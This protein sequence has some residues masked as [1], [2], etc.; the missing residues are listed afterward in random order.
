MIRQNENLGAV[1]RFAQTCSYE[2]Q[3]SEQV[4]LLAGRLFDLLKPVHG[5]SVEQKWLLTAAALLHDIGWMQ[6][7]SKHHKMAMNMILSDKT[8]PLE[9]QDRNLIALIARY[10]RKALPNESHPIYGQLS[11]GQKRMVDVLGGILRLADGLDRSHTSAIERLDV[12]IAAGSI[13]VLCFGSQ[14]VSEEIQY[15]RKKAD[16]LEQSLKVKIRVTCR[17]E[18]RK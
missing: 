14:S 7:Q 2:Q 15:G 4:A 17:D 5:I 12:E 8:M 16:L 11:A 6:G 1:R 18:G 9:P 13:D 10:H 3:H